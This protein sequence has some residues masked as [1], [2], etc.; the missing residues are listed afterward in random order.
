MDMFNLSGAI[1]SDCRKYRYALWRKWDE[2][3]PM[4]MFIGLNPSKA[5][6]YEPDPTITRVIQFSKSMGYGGV[7]M[8][9]LYAIVDSNPDVLKT[10]PDPLGENDGWVEKIAPECQMIIFAWGKFKEAKSRADKF[11]KMFPEG[12]CLVKNK[13][14][15]PR[16][17]LYVKGDTV[18]VKFSV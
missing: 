3:K 11:I 9:N 15:S 10:H 17:P 8:M 4:I 7:Y 14:G 18:P 2:T 12:H 1:F 16:H 13:D 5:N 6:E